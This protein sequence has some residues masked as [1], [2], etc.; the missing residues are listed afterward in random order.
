MYYSGLLLRPSLVD[1]YQYKHETMTVVV[2]ALCNDHTDDTLCSH[3][4]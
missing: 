4:R 2:L 1:V 3:V